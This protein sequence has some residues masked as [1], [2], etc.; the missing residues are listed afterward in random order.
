MADGNPNLHVALLV[1]GAGHVGRYLDAGLPSQMSP[2]NL[3]ALVGSGRRHVYHLFTTA[4]DYTRIQRDPLFTALSG[5][6]EVRP[7][8]VD[9]LVQRFERKEC[10]CYELLNEIYAR[11]MAEAL[12]EGAG[13]LPI[14]PD[15]VFSDGT[16][17][18]LDQLARE[19]VRCVAI[20]AN[21]AFTS[22]IGPLRA[23]FL[24]PG[25]GALSITPRELVG[26]TLA[27]LSPYWEQFFADH[28]YFPSHLATHIQWR[29]GDEGI[30]ARSS[31]LHPIYLMPTPESC[32][33][34][35]QG[36]KEGIDG[37]GFYATLTG[38]IPRDVH[39]VTD[40]DELCLT[41]TDPRDQAFREAPAP[42]NLT[43]M[44]TALMP[45][46]QPHTG[47]FYRQSIRFHSGPLGPAWEPVAREADQVVDA[48]MAC[49]EIWQRW[50]ALF[51]GTQRLSRRLPENSDFYPFVLQRM[52]ALAGRW[53]AAGTRVAVFGTGPWARVILDRT[54]LN[55][56][57]IAAVVD[58][59]PVLWDTP[60]LEWTIRPPGALASLAADIII[61][62]SM[63]F[64]EEMVRQIQA[65]PGVAGEIVRLFPNP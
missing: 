16:F 22:I 61:V 24:D 65:M 36:T 43:E 48:V 63:G 51:A 57:M 56:C 41:G 44:A 35:F 5:Q 25:T 50:P 59:N 18:R 6:L 39:I 29:V 11:A 45:R 1:F 23:V 12:A 52:E 17:R 49:V 21:Q 60:W 26:L 30:L 3:P 38:D 53:R 58:S 20:A 9:D 40:S 55:R 62:T 8:L 4:E 64:Q 34:A 19:G 14:W 54:A 33:F 13:L 42:L 15:A 31:F 32:A 7:H 27:H 47:H 46:L 10:N 2:G 28:P 37:S